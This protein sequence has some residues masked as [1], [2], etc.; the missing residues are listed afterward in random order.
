MSTKLSV[1]EPF[2]V[3]EFP[4]SVRITYTTAEVVLELTEE[5]HTERITF[6]PVQAMKVTT[7]DCFSMRNRG[8][9]VHKSIMEEQNSAW[10]QEL[11]GAAARID[12]SS[13]FMRKAR[14]FIVPCED[15]FIE[16]IAW[17]Y[18]RNSA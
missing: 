5:R 15:Q 17:D 2:L 3:F 10:L 1:L 9:I 12:E 8:Q 6:Y 7:A 18:V 14:H 13:E 4:P 11:S 16:V